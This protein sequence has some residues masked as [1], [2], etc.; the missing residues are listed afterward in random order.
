MVKITGAKLGRDVTKRWKV[1]ASNFKIDAR[2]EE[3]QREDLFA[4]MDR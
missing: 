1:L 3:I 4:G 2:F